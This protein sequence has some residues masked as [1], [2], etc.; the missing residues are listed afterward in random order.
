MGIGPR[1]K[2]TEGALFKKEASGPSQGEDL[3]EDFLHEGGMKVLQP[4]LPILKPGEI[5]LA[6]PN[7]AEGRRAGPVKKEPHIEVSF[8]NPSHHT[9]K[10]SRPVIIAAPFSNGFHIL[11]TSINI[12]FVWPDSTVLEDGGFFLSAA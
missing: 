6:Q 11:I 9:L 3:G 2:G 7:T 5:A 8:M 1:D 4:L 12:S 10:P